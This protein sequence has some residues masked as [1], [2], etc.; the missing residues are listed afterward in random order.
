M[1]RRHAGEVTPHDRRAG[2]GHQS[3]HVAGNEVLGDVRRHAEHQVQHARRKPR[4]M[5]GPGDVHGTGRC[6]LGGL[7]DDR[8]PRRQSAGHLAGRL[9]EREVPG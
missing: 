9:A 8:A 1:V 2:E 6:L 3:D 5:E 7:E 4:V